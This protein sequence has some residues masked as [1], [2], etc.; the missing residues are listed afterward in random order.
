MLEKGDSRPDGIH[1]AGRTCRQMALHRKH[2]GITVRVSVIRM[3]GIEP[4]YS[5]KAGR[6]H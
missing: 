6:E 4:M 3:L 1:D 2:T 5:Q